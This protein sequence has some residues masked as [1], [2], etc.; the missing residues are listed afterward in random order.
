M[1][2]KNS[3]LW[4]KIQ[5]F[6][7]DAPN[8]SLS[9]SRRL[10]REN[11]WSTAFANRV[12]DEY[13]KFTYLA[14]ISDQTVTPSDE[15]DQAWHLHLTYTRNYW[16]QFCGVILER[17]LH[18]EPTRGGSDED[19]KY[20][21]F[22]NDTLELY[23]K[24]FGHKPPMDIWPSAD[25]RF[26]KAVRMKR[27]DTSQNWLIPKKLLLR[28]SAMAFM[29]LGSL[30]L[31]GCQVLGYQVSEE[32]II[33]GGLILALFMV[34]IYLLTKVKRKGGGCGSGGSGCGSGCSSGCGGGG[35]G[36]D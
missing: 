24:E 29:F 17:A 20:E 2:L 18:H 14:C 11:S 3:E 25:I 12:I 23:E 30:T 19:Q 13:R 7:F 16:D 5:K 4:H 35:C 34:L 10:A 32:Q 33:I 27:I 6:S 28:P 1:A 36:G 15:V 21:R 31:A 26:S 22:Y 8:A 9:M